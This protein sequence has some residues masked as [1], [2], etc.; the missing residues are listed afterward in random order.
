[1]FAWKRTADEVDV[2]GF[3]HRTHSRQGPLVRCISNQKLGSSRTERLFNQ[4]LHKPQL[5]EPPPSSPLLKLIRHSEE[6]ILIV[7]HHV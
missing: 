2:L 4:L 5:V 7:V 3:C 1:M 6:T